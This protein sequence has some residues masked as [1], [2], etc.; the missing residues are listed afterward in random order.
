MCVVAWS[1][2]KTYFN[3]LYSRCSPAALI[4]S[5]PASVSWILGV[6]EVVFDVWEKLW[7]A[8]WTNLRGSGIEPSEP[9]QMA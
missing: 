3:S 1:L 7:L 2:W 9:K 8:A 5:K 4:L 6:S